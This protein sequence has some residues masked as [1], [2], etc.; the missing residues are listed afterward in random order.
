MVITPMRAAAATVAAFVGFYAPDTLQAQIYPNRSVTIVVPNAAGGGTDTV[1]RLV[2]DQ[3]S[4][5]LGQG[6]CGR[7]SDRWWH[8][9]WYHRRRQSST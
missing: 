3:L 2:G 6:L 8:A 9:G 7:E 1:A 5:Q 4:K